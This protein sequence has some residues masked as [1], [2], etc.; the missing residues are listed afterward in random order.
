M[1]GRS[2]LTVLVAALVV[3]AAT[4]C[5][6]ESASDKA[7]SSICVA[8]SD[9]QTQITDLKRT[10][11]ANA[12][13]QDVNTNLTVIKSDLRTIDDA[14]PDL[15]GDTK[16]QLQTATETFKLSISSTLI[17]LFTN[18]TSLTEARGRLPG[19]VATLNSS[20]QQAFN[21]FEC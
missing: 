2:A 21:S 1:V 12:T 19:A 4:A 3:G 5:G 16:L 7:K 8:K 15:D 17:P 20:Y 9:I 6:G 11:E 14:L 10:T 18:Q 13:L